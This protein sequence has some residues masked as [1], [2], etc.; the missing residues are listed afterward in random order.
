M[1]VKEFNFPLPFFKKKFEELTS[2]RTSDLANNNGVITGCDWRMEKML[3]WWWENY[4]A[5]NPYPVT[6]IDF[7]LSSNMRRWCRTLGGVI[8]LE[9]PLYLLKKRINC[10]LK[11]LEGLKP[12][13]ILHKQ[14]R[15]MCF[16]K[17]PFALLQSP[18][19][20]T[21]WIDV[22]CEI[23]DNLLDLFE[24]SKNPHGISLTPLSPHKHLYHLQRGW[25]KPNQKMF[26]CGVISYQRGA[27]II[28][29]W[30]I[31]VVTREKFYYADQNILTDLIYEQ[32]I[33]FPFF[34][35]TYNWVLK[36][37]G[38]NPTAK[39]LHYAGIDVRFDPKSFSRFS[40]ILN[41]NKKGA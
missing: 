8:N 25:I 19:R 3:P 30:A 36:E 41:E 14:L 20:R 4:K 23:K 12:K 33:D 5:H 9:V 24:Y 1:N 28:Q 38:M 11:E 39:V 31:A 35:A 26:N 34:P 21:V 18:Y 10:P 22:D 37:W 6:F 40:F 16:F 29:Q 15:R 2:W 13:K 17:K 27:R 32:K 7:G